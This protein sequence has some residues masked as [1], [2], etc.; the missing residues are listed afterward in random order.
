GGY[1]PV[2]V[3]EQFNSGRY[4][5]LHYLGQGHYSTVWMVH[6]TLTQ[7]QVAMKVV[8]SAENYTEAARDEVTLLTQIRDNDPDGANHCVRLLDQFEHTGPHGRHVCEV[9]E[10]MGDDLLTLIRA[11]EHRGIPLHIVRHLTR[12]TLVA[13]DYLHIKCQIVH[14]DL[15]P[16]NV[17]LTESVQPRGTPNSSL[18]KVGGRRLGLGWQ[19][20]EGQCSCQPLQRGAGARVA[21]HYAAFPCP[22]HAWR[23]TPVLCPT[24]PSPPRPLPLCWRQVDKE[25]LEPRLLRMGCKIV[26]FGNACWTDRQF[27]QNI[28]TRQYRAPEVIL[29]AGY[30]DSADIWSLA[31]MVFE[32][33]TGDFLFQPNAR[34]QYSKDE[35]HLAQM[36]ELLGAMPAE[37]A[38]AGKHSAEFFTSG[39]ALRNID[40]LNLWPLE[41]VLQEKYFLPAAEA[42]QL[43]D[44]LLPMLHFDPAKRASA[45]DM[46]RHPWL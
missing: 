6:D 7:Q 5:V 45:A 44:F 22:T 24:H 28:Q 12:Q 21:P 19:A 30:D 46:L 13:L 43:R 29:G 27:S 9:F 36:I 32:L 38:G 2:Q 20:R 8:R 1:H 18:L 42:Q 10:A 25:E 16:E 11:Y 23:R 37:V 3:G 4:T 34:G 40:E 14:T 41:Q 15:K 35:D 31:C 39:G 17:M 26:D 33:V